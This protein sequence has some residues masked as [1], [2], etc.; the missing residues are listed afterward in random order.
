MKRAADMLVSSPDTRKQVMVVMTDGK[1]NR[2]PRVHDVLNDIVSA[3]PDL[4]IYSLGLGNDFDG[5]V[6]QSI[7]TVGN[8]Y[9]QVSA[10]L[11]GNN[12]FALEEF[13]FKIYSNAT[14]AD[15]IV[16]PTRAVDLSTGAITVVYSAHVV[17][18]DRYATF[19]VLDDPALRAFYKLELISPTGQVMD[20]G[21]SVAGIPIQVMRR[22][23][24]TIYKVIF[25][26]ISQSASYIGDWKV[27]L[28][29]TK[30]WNPK[31]AKKASERYTQAQGE[32]IQPYL[33]LVPVG[34]GA[35]VKSDYHMEVAVT[36]NSYQPGANVL[37]TAKLTDR[38]WPSSGTVNLTATRPNNAVSNFVLY[39]DGT[40]GD[41]N[42]GDGIYSNTYNQ[43]ALNGS[44]KFYFKG[45]GI[46]ERG[47]LVPRE[48]T[49]Y[50]SLSTPPK[51]DGGEGDHCKSC[52]PCWVKWLMLILLLFILILIIR[53]IRR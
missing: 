23:N 7:T 29:P 35:A 1:E 38:G 37:L 52:L 30:K 10:D 51:T 14:G 45:I 50:V 12:I 9:H 6:L 53:Y 44:Y 33:G 41:I 21:S 22:M 15:L 25:P 19:L 20:P 47:E 42:S 32:Y 5:S 40:H 26:D 31:D 17:S 2:D 39:D 8:G 34:F 27:I 28:T 49:R 36:A 3:N 18:S 4:M 11:L 46:N 24:Y 13:Y 48:A 16:D 43:T